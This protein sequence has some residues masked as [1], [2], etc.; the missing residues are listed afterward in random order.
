MSS[1]LAIL[2]TLLSVILAL[3]R[4]APAT[5]AAVQDRQRRERETEAARHLGEKDASVDAALKRYEQPK[6]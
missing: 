1:A 2:G 3:L 5:L 6:P 4:V